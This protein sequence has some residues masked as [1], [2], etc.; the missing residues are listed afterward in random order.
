VAPAL[1]VRVLTIGREEIRNYFDK[2]IKTIGVRNCYYPLFIS[3]D[4][5]EKEQSHVEGFSA[6][7]AWVTNGGKSKLEKPSRWSGSPCDS[8]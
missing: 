1:R 5:L 2:K 4:N 3:R 8:F 6:E 7:V